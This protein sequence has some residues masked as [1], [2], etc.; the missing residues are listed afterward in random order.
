M[1]G[2]Q[3]KLHLSL[4]VSGLGL[5]CF[6][7]AFISRLG[8]GVAR[9][10]AKTST[11]RALSLVDCFLWYGVWGAT[12]VVG[13]VAIVQTFMS[14]HNIAIAVSL[15]WFHVKII[16]YLHGQLGSALSGTV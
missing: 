5:E 2:I 15:V 3:K 11:A 12:I 16:F 7:F 8:T 9:P 14:Q 13:S 4:N 10:D 6:D 1:V